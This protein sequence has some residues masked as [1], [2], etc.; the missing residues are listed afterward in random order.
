MECKWLGR[1]LFI[2]FEDTNTLQGKQASGVLLLP[3]SL[4]S[5]LHDDR[6]VTVSVHLALSDMCCD[7]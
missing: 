3:S 1:N 6:D 4:F 7:P 5:H 2:A